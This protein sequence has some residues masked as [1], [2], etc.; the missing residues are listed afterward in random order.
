MFNKYKFIYALFFI[1]FIGYQTVFSMDWTKIENE[2]FYINKVAFDK[3]NKNR[4]FVAADYIPLDYSGVDF[5]IFNFNGLGGSGMRL[6]EDGGKTYTDNIYFANMI[7]LDIIQDPLKPQNWHA[8]VVEN[9]RGVIYNSNDNGLTWSS[10]NSKCDGTKHHIKLVPTKTENLFHIASVNTGLGYSTSNDA[11]TN[12]ITNN[13]LSV[14]ARDLKVSEVTDGLMYIA[15]ASDNKP[16]VYK[17]INNG[18][19]WDKD[20]AGI[21][22]LRIHSVMPSPRYDNL[23][24][25]GADSVLADGSAIGKGLYRSKDGGLTWHSF[26][27]SGYP[28]YDIQKHPTMPKYMLAACGNG[29]LYSSKSF[30]EAWE[31]VEMNGLQDSSI[32]RIYIPDFEEGPGEDGGFKAMVEVFNSG[33]YFSNDYIKPTLVSVDD[34]IEFIENQRVFP[35]PVINNSFTIEF[36]NNKEQIVKYGLYTITGE[37]LYEFNNFESSGMVAKEFHLNKIDSIQKLNSGIYILEID[38]GNKKIINKVNIIN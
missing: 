29:G 5:E 28:V 1:S 12:C 4:F 19:T 20:V 27:I 24:Y 8:S 9:T 26:F 16:G 3:T 6:T 7:V 37:L 21:R 23:V 14:S 13:D 11:F 25:C 36:T 17:S 31:K 38:L 22:N 30:G 35:N 34:E 32:R 33:L 2:N 10:E 18:Q 15:G